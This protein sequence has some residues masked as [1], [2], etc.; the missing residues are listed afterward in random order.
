[1]SW[2]LANT[3]LD[4]TIDD[5]IGNAILKFGG[6]RPSGLGNIVMAWLMKYCPWHSTLW[7]MVDTDGKAPW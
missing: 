5:F 6:D 3:I 2:A 4:S 7:W 1:V